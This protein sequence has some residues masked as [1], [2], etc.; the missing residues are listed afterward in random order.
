MKIGTKTA[1]QVEVGGPCLLAL[2]NRRNHGQTFLSQKRYT[3]TEEI[4]RSSEGWEEGKA[5]G[6]LLEVC[7]GKSGI[8]SYHI[9]NLSL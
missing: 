1:I 5:E 3:E 4:A 8:F 9:T 2:L 7:V 6:E